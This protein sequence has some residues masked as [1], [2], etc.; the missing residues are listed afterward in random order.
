MRYGVSYDG[1]TNQ[2]SGHERCLMPSID[3]YWSMIWLRFL[4]RIDNIHSS[5][6]SGFVLMIQ[7]HGG[8]GW[9]VAG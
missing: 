7:S 5:H 8:M 4:I 2:M 6:Q 9:V 3:G 1:V